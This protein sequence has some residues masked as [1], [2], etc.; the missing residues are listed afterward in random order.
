[1]PSAA[2]LL[3]RNY[4]AHRVA[5]GQHDAAMIDLSRCVR[6]CF[7]QAG[8]F[9]KRSA[10]GGAPVGQ[11]FGAGD[12]AALAANALHTQELNGLTLPPAKMTIPV[13]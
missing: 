9:D 6:R 8:P 5:P 3:R 4:P 13:Q 10:A 2:A 12:G 11:G 7:V 1:M